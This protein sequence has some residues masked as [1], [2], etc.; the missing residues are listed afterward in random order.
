MRYILNTPKGVEINDTDPENQERYVSSS[1]LFVASSYKHSID[2]TL[3]Y[4]DDS[5]DNIVLN[6]KSVILLHNL[7]TQRLLLDSD[8]IG[9]FPVMVHEV[10]KTLSISIRGEL[11]Y[12]LDFNDEGEFIENCLSKDIKH[13]KDGVIL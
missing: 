6:K 12:S 5:I 7:D 2:V 4:E 10:V 8:K 13:T 3:V 11:V 9:L 1:V